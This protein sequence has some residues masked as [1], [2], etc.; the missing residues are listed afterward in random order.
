VSDL[1][2]GNLFAELNAEAFALPPMPE[3]MTSFG[4]DDAE[5][6]AQGVDLE[7]E[8]P[9]DQWQALPPRPPLASDPRLPR[10][11]VDGA[12]QS[13]EIAGSVQ[14]HM[15][16]AR[17]IRAGQMGAGALSLDWPTEHQIECCNFV[18]VSASGFQAAQLVPLRAEL[19]EGKP[20]FALV[21]WDAFA[22]TY[23][24]THTEQI[25]AAKDVVTV[26]AK[27]RR[28]VLAEMLE[29]EQGLVRRLRQPVYAD[30]RF[31]EHVPTDDRQLVIGIIKTLRQ[32]YLDPLRTLMLYK[33]RTGE[34]TPAFAM[35]SAGRYP[36]VSF[37]LR[38]SSEWAGG[39][40]GLVRIEL[41]QSHFEEHKNKDWALLDAIAAHLTRLR[42]RDYS[43]QRA[44]VTVEPIRTIEA[45]L[46][47]ILLPR[48]RVAMTALNRLRP[49]RNVSTS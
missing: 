26:R 6:I 40:D 45:R 20:S 42:T 38:L 48:E 22:D 23:L 7:Y 31:A 36:A 19:A 2:C 5:D 14:D 11:F 29:L 28:Q 25:A 12:L 17:S 46:H 16:F 41:A 1:T 47:G 13:N 24:R 8:L 43:Y 49:G 37:Y 39:A 33:L 35:L 44:A 15:G 9:F 4:D 34:R 30:G 27:V 18:A 21:T 3:E 10:L 32:R